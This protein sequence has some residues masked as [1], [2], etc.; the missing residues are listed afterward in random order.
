MKDFSISYQRLVKEL[1]SHT[2]GK[3]G[4]TLV[5]GLIIEHGKFNAVDYLDGFASFVNSSTFRDCKYWIDSK[6]DVNRV[7]AHNA[8]MTAF[9]SLY[10][11]ISKECDYFISLA[12]KWLA[13]QF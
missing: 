6:A 5:D 7:K 10:P 1:D 12:Q 9:K 13:S 8:I 4:A 3:D 2:K 11:Q